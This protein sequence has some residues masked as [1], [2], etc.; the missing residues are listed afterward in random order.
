MRVTVILPDGDGLICIKNS[1]LEE[2][3]TFWVSLRILH[4]LLLSSIYLV[5]GVLEDLYQFVFH[6]TCLLQEVMDSTFIFTSFALPLFLSGSL[7]CL[8]NPHYSIFNSYSLS[9]VKEPTVLYITEK[10]MHSLKLPLV[11]SVLPLHFI[12][13]VLL[14]CYMFNF[15]SHPAFSDVV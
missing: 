11:Y 3:S 1:F 7:W 4:L 2:L 10:S 14:L 6:M 12:P 5:F 8:V 15:S 13:F 9:Y